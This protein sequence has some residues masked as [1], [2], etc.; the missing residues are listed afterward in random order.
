MCAH[1]CVREY[2][3]T[4]H[5]CMH[6]CIGMYVKAPNLCCTSMYMCECTIPLALYPG[7][8][9]E[10]YKAN[11]MVCMY[12]TFEPGCETSHLT[13]INIHMH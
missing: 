1:A 5:A 3:H 8:E 12:I 10:G 7:S 2:V 4:V 11:M 6:V 9:E 13:C